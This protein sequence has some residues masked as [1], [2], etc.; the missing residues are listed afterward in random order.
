MHVSDS[1]V[2]SELV[3]IDKSTFLY[4]SDMFSLESVKSN[5]QSTVQ[6]ATQK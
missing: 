6:N 2:H 1:F 3:K 4:N 5:C